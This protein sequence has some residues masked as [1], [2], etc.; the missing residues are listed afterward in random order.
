MKGLR[1][2]SGAVFLALLVGFGSSAAARWVLK[3]PGP[4][5][6]QVTLVI[7]KGA[8]SLATGAQL[9]AAGVVS[10]RYVFALAAHLDRRG[11]KAGEYLFQPHQRLAGVVGELAAGRVVEHHLTIPEGL[12][13]AQIRQLILA[14]PALTGEL[15]TPPPEG[16]LLPETYNFTYGDTRA[17]LIARM[18]A[19]ASHALETAWA[20]R[21]PQTLLK[22]SQEA[23]VM[24]SIV[25]KETG[26]ATERP[27]VAAVFLNRLRQG[28]K[29][30][31]DPTVIYA[32]DGG[33]GPLD[34][35]LTHADLAI[36]SP[37]NTYV[38]TGLP[39]GSICNPGRLA[40]AA[41]L[42]P[43]PQPYLYFV[44]TGTGGHAFAETLAEHNRNVAE[45]VKTMHD[46]AP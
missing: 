38:V 5:T 45:W 8:S 37:Y 14:E 31:S 33:Q 7:P 1:R 32:L 29:L 15:A 24:A 9:Q 16:S 34:R 12:T 27:L 25:E 13:S 23:L 41:A 28:M 4:L 21:D 39:P 20:G 6:A 2:L 11:I 42:H 10:S 43:A 17:A 22:S 26:V 18:Q 40:L 19:A 3:Q 30:Q 35:S 36:E 46:R 44:A